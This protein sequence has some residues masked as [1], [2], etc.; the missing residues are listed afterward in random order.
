VP[1]H[2]AV[3]VQTYTI[4]YLGLQIRKNYCLESLLFTDSSPSTKMSD[5]SPQTVSGAGLGG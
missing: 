2:L 4:F 1:L 5:I 3:A